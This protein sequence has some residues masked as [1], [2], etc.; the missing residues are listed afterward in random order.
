MTND[1]DKS[2]EEQRRSAKEKVDRKNARNKAARE[3]RSTGRQ[4][5]HPRGPHLGG[6]K[7]DGA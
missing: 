5:G 1:K 3:A 6:K 4:P 2:A 7:K